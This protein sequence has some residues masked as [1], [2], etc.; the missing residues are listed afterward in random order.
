MTLH[1]D[2]N[3][4]LELPESLRAALHLEPESQV[5]AG[6]DGESIVLT[7]TKPVPELKQVG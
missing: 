2:Q 3:G 6:L 5:Q 7:A 4:K 1:I